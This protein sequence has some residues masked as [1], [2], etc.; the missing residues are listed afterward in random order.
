[1]AASRGRFICQSQSLN[2]FMDKPDFRKLSSMHF[3]SWRKG[4]KTGI[5]YLRTKPVA[6]AQQ[7]TIEPD[8]KTGKS[9]QSP[10]CS[11]DDQECLS[12]GS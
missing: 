6:Q 11:R 1:M 12:C 3:Y 4:L 10:V 5:Y 8:K 7:F 9:D 2:L